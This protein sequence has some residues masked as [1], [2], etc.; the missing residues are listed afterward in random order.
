MSDAQS[1]TDLIDKTFVK[2]RF[3]TSTY[4]ILKDVRK[5]KVVLQQPKRT[6]TFT[7]STSEF[8]KFYRRVE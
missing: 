7:L 6:D 3:G 4:V 1:L 2:E 5:N 8:L